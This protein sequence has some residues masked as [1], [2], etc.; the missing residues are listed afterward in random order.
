VALDFPQWQTKNS[1]EPDHGALII[2]AMTFEQWRKR[3]ER[4]L[5]NGTPAWKAFEAWRKHLENFQHSA[6]QMASGGALRKPSP[7]GVPLSPF[8]ANPESYIMAFLYSATLPP[9][10]NDVQL[11]KKQ[12][13]QDE[14]VLKELER[15]AKEAEG[16]VARFSKRETGTRVASEDD[17]LKVDLAPLLQQYKEVAQSSRWAIL[18][19]R[20]PYLHKPDVL[21]RCLG[22]IADL[23]RRRIREGK[24]GVPVINDRQLGI[25]E[26]QALALIRSALLAQGHSEEEIASL[27]PLKARDG[28]VRK[29]LDS[30]TRDLIAI[31]DAI[32][33]QTRKK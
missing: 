28:N 21:D 30:R 6:S 32:S 13:K 24:V 9:S 16:F 12:H 2:A 33:A 3:F 10:E 7:K 26:S 4:S 8:T 23:T 29:R 15:L 19:L 18:L 1:E 20:R 17:Y 25:P 11:Q 27:D 14:Y 31:F 22:L 5:R